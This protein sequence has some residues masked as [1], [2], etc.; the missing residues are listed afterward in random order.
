MIK[1]RSVAPRPH[2]A[3]PAP[4]QPANPFG[5]VRG[6]V[7]ADAVHAPA[8]PPPFAAYCS[9]N[10]ISPTIGFASGAG[11]LDGTIVTACS[12]FSKPLASRIDGKF[13]DIEADRPGHVRMI[14]IVAMRNRRE[15]IERPDIV[16]VDRIGRCVAGQVQI[17]TEDRIGLG[18]RLEVVDDQIEPAV[19]R[20]RGQPGGLAAKPPARLRRRGRRG[21]LQVHPNRRGAQRHRSALRFRHHRPERPLAARRPPR[22]AAM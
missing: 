5:A 20:Q 19:F 22:A 2:A 12:A 17:D 18:V 14:V 10:E 9:T 6:S 8:Q 21:S 16:T 3:R 15:E 13:G 1:R 4:R 7:A 11:D